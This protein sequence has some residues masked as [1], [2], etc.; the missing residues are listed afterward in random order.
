LNYTR[1]SLAPTEWRIKV[2]HNHI[3]IVT[4]TEKEA[5]RKQKEE[6]GDEKNGAG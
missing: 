1:H 3:Q 4:K 2:I 6:G 5:R